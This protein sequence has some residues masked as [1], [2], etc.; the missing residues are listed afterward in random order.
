MPWQHRCSLNT[1]PCRGSKHVLWNAQKGLQLAIIPKISPRY[2]VVPGSAAPTSQAG[3]LMTTRDLCWAQILDL[4]GIFCIFSCSCWIQHFRL[5]SLLG[6]GLPKFLQNHLLLLCLKK[7][8]ISNPLSLSFLI[9]SVPAFTKM[10]IFVWRGCLAVAVMRSP[11]DLTVCVLVASCTTR[12]LRMLSRQRHR[13]LFD[14]EGR[15]VRVTPRLWPREQH[16]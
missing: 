4:S 14:A 12:R 9:W 2:W 11:G 6:S 15:R 1:Q 7:M 5:K 3:N 13:P 10:I 8:G 16:S